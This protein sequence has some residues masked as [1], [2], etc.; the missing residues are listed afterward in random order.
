MTSNSNQTEQQ[1]REKGLKLLENLLKENDAKGIRE[2]LKEIFYGYIS[3]EFS[4]DKLER[5]NKY[6]TYLNLIEFLTKLSKLDK[7]NRF[8]K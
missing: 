8:S 6:S 7:I 5:N 3:S 4:D 2:D 1:Q